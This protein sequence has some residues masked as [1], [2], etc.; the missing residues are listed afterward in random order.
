MLHYEAFLSESI[1]FLSQSV[2]GLPRGTEGKCRYPRADPIFW[3]LVIFT[4]R[5]QVPTV[6]LYRIAVQVPLSRVQAFPLLLR[7]FCAL[8][9]NVILFLAPILSSS[10][11]TRLLPQGTGACRRQSIVSGAS[12]TLIQSFGSSQSS[13]F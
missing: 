10:S 4:Q 1:G 8:P 3:K 11:S 5:D 2:Q 12:V 6:L 7:E 13:P 9:L